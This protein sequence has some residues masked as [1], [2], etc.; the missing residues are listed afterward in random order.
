MQKKNGPSSRP[1]LS[2][3]G[4]LSRPGEKQQKA[5][6]CLFFALLLAVGFMTCKDYGVPWDLPAEMNILRMNLWEYTLWLGGDD[7]AFKNYAATETDSIAAG[8]P[9]NYVK[10]ISQSMEWDHGQGILYP[11][12][13][14]IMNESLADGTRTALIFAYL[15]FVFWLG[16]IALYHI[17]RH[18]CISRGLSCASV[19]ILMLSPRFFAEAH[20]NNKDI[21]LMSLTFI[22]LWQALRL[23]QRPSL[24]AALLLGI[25]GAFATNTKVIG[26]AL[27]GLMGLFVL[28]R[29]A[30]EKRLDLKVLGLGL[31]SMTALAVLY[32]ALTPALWTDPLAFLKY[33]IA[34][35]LGFSRWSGYVLFRGSFFSTSVSPLPWY[36][37]PYTM[38]VT[39]PLWVWLLMAVGQCAALVCIFGR[40]GPSSLRYPLLLITLLWFIPLVFAILTRTFV[41]NGW[42]HFY[43]LYAPI[44]VLA[45]HGLS[46]FM[47]HMWRSKPR[48]L[49]AA[50]LAACMGLTGVQML[51]N[52]PYEYV[53]YNPLLA[54]K[55]INTFMERDYW[56]VSVKDAL[57]ALCQLE[58]GAD[59]PVAIA[60]S[61]LWAD[62]GIALSLSSLSHPERLTLA[63]PGATDAK[64]YLVNH[65]YQ[66]FSGWTPTPSMTPAVQ[67]MAFGQPLV[68][69]YTNTQ[70]EYP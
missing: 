61:D 37:L 24:S 58:S 31:V 60:G 59:Q 12:A 38:L 57:E 13:G 46:R 29:L 63:S 44:V 18:L 19:V 1:P 49:A 5:L 47:G 3:P 68:T 39:T 8:Y 42:R 28:L 22:M 35:T 23:M 2:R 54:G 21:V 17:S 55:S 65:T 32:I 25:A 34:N 33:N 27:F 20:Y 64:Y 41:Y 56:N 70:E 6:V 11:L 45:G 43:F 15:W 51:L 10:P 67:I 66:F 52:H 50:A 4:F 9:E 48:R 14:L 26:L 40:K 62:T 30:A 53:Y 36:Y 69:V 7:T 16:A